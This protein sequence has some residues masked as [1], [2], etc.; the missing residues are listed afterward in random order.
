MSK[1]PSSIRNFLIL[2]F[3]I[4][5]ALQSLAQAPAI[6]S[7]SPNAGPVGTAVTITGANFSST[8]SNN[9]VYFGAVKATVTA[10]TTT[11]L[12]VTVPAGTTYQPFTV[13]TNHLT[14]WSP[15]PFVTTFSGGGAPLTPGSFALETDITT[16]LH[17]YGAVIV[18]LDG[19]GIPD[20]A[21]P[22]NA[23][24][25]ASL[26]SVVRNTSSGGVISFDTKLDFP[27]PSGSLPNSMAAA[28]IDGDGLPD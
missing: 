3:L 24:S 2:C 14:A 27:A 1:L 20:L 25:P 19:D 28:D 21:T 15:R 23:N 6:T 9:I 12:T 26:I 17:P 7:F 18:D 11:T 4:L 10:A 13:T 16:N 22:N 5:S 8:A